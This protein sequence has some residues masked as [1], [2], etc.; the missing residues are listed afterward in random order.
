[1]LVGA[2]EAIVSSLNWCSHTV[3]IDTMYSRRPLVDVAA[4]L[5]VAGLSGKRIE[6]VEVKTVFSE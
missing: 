5:D 3:T 4:I 6:K 1:M 2:I